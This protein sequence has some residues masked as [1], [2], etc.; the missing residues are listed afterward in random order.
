M[1]LYLETEKNRFKVRAKKFIP[2]PGQAVLSKIGGHIESAFINP[3]GW[4]TIIICCN[5]PEKKI[6]IFLRELDC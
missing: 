2:Y 3:D 4:S 6:S 1:D 5:N